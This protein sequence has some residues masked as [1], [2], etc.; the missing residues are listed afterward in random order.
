MESTETQRL[1]ALGDE[2][3][4]LG[5]VSVPAVP[6]ESG[7]RA[8]IVARIEQIQQYWNDLGV[9][10]DSITLTASPG[11]IEKLGLLDGSDTL[12]IECWLDVNDDLDDESFWITPNSTL[13]G[14][15][16]STRPITGFAFPNPVERAEI[17]TRWVLQEIDKMDPGA[18]SQAAKTL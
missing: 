11:L 10:F 7:E 4:R 18:A 6:L 9:E 15:V 17:E 14:L 5:K 1:L 13:V 16:G 12:G 2:L 3:N 8:W